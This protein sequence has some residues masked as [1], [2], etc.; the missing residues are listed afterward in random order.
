MAEITRTYI[1]K[2]DDC[3]AKRTKRQQLTNA[4]KKITSEKTTTTSDL[5]RLKS[6]QHN[7]HVEG[8]IYS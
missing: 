8:N 3:T 6:Q 2:K 5:L 1:F 4:Y 7:G